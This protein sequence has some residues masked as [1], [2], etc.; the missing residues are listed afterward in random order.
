MATGYE[1]IQFFQQSQR[2][3]DDAR[4]NH[5]LHMAL[6]DAGREQAEF[7]G[8]PVK[9]HR[10]PGVVTALIADNDVMTFRQDIDDFSFGF[11]TPLQTNHRCCRHKNARKENRWF[12]KETGHR[13]APTSGQK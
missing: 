2:I 9:L 1:S 3:D 5:R 8:S 12:Q 11:V 6:Q 13:H 10:M 4:G 7:V